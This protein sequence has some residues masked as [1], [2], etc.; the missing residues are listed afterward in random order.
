MLTAAKLALGPLLLKQAGALRRTALRLPEA[1]GAREGLV[2]EGEA[3]LRLLVVGD[4]SAAGVGV[5]HQSQALALPL[6]RLMAQELRVPV[7][8]Q[9]VAE[10][11]L[12]T[13]GARALLARSRLAPADVVVTALGVNDVT[14]Q[15]SAGA[16]ITHTSQLWSDLRQRTGAR[17][18]VLSGL[19]PMHRLSAV[20][21]PLRW[22]LGRYAAGF[23]AALSEWAR[24][25]ELGYCGLRWTDDPAL[26][27]PDGFHPGPALYPQW[28]RQLADRII[29]GQR[30]WAVPR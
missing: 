17:W 9:L 30:R 18:A 28:A 8:W 13:A 27:A 1:G 29:A 12:N 19:P 11:G 3:G 2:G 22:Y 21:Q 7:A 4:S 23:D 5:Q 24:R 26:L 10:T 16:F 14:A 20:P 25:Q 15:L 6:A